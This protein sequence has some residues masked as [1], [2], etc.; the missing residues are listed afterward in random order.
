MS[1]VVANGI[2]SVA[3]IFKLNN[4][5]VVRSLADVS[6]EDCW[7]R[8]ASGNPLGWLLGHVTY[9]R[10]SLIRTLGFPYDPGIG[11]GFERGSQLAGP[12]DYP[13]RVVLENAWRDTRGRMREA[14]EALTDAKLAEPAN[15][16]LPG[17]KTLADLI[18]FS[19]FHESYHVGQMGYVRRLLGQTGIAG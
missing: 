7:R 19:A 10:A 15:R 12:R 9:S 1:S 6:D 16:S 4:E 8:P 2:G 3:L 14:F 11:K 18:A 5:M 17:V 13:A